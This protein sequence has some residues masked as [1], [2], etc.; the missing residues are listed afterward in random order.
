[1]VTQE[2]GQ[3]LEEAL[4]TYYPSPDFNREQVILLVAPQSEERSRTLSKLLVSGYIVQQLPNMSLAAQHL[5]KAYIEAVVA[6]VS[7]SMPKAEDIRSGNREYKPNEGEAFRFIQQ[8]KAADP[9]L[10]VIP[11]N[12]ERVEI[13]RPAIVDLKSMSPDRV[14]LKLTH[15][16]FVR[17]FQPEDIDLFNFAEMLQRA[18]AL[19]IQQ[20]EGIMRRIGSNL[21]ENGSQLPY[22]IGEDARYIY[23]KNPK[24]S[25][26]W[27]NDA[28]T[29]GGV[30][31]PINPN[32]QYPK[33]AKTF[34]IKRVTIEESAE[35]PLTYDTLKN[36]F[37]QL[38][39]K[40]PF[41][42]PEQLGNH[43][44]GNNEA[45]ALRTFRIASNYS[46]IMRVLVEGIRSGADTDGAVE[47]LRREIL[48]VF[49]E[50]R[51]PDWYS[52]SHKLAMDEQ[53]RPARE[54]LQLQQIE[55]ML[56]LPTKLT[57]IS[58]KPVDPAVL[59]SLR[60]D[61]TALY[62]KHPGGMRDEVYT[63]AMSSKGH[64][65]ALETGRSNPTLELLT[66]KYLLKSKKDGSTTTVRT[67]DHSSIS[68]DFAFWDFNMQSVVSTLFSDMNYLL[69]DSS[70]FI[71]EKEKPEWAFKSLEVIFREDPRNFYDAL[72]V[73]GIHHNALRAVQTA[74][75]GQVHN[76][77]AAIGKLRN[78]ASIESERTELDQQFMHYIEQVVKFTSLAHNFWL[79]EAEKL[80][81][82]EGVDIITEHFSDKG[83]WV[84]ENGRGKLLYLKRIFAVYDGLRANVHGLDHKLLTASAL[85]TGGPSIS[86]R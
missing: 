77:R 67:P 2:K 78:P 35:F 71:P 56:L 42:T 83:A 81:L 53:H 47:N 52:M 26:A 11:I 7:K 40:A 72:F 66:D 41:R 73:Q 60:L 76:Y 34:Q 3:S 85:R 33:T 20:F 4:N 18:I 58:G 16:G 61:V 6:D 8:I 13:H 30:V 10:P 12:L 57:D 43:I 17:P 31:A 1:M 37:R 29:L 32:K 48:R 15:E 65:I 51:L 23:S 74:I 9:Y 38:H 68:S 79:R 49:F 5:Q 21:P 75:H 45:Y 86:Y 63:L 69:N 39:P 25:T 84:L 54:K 44:T 22:D 24:G 28:M 59:A 14:E 70:V 64:N 46:D 36:E 27:D 82:E 62:A 50:E 19:R 55:Q 80:P